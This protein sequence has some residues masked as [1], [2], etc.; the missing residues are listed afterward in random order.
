MA[1]PVH[2]SISENKTCPEPDF[3][4]DSICDDITNIFE[5]DYDGGDCCSQ[6]SLDLYCEACICYQV[7]Q[8]DAG[9]YTVHSGFSDIFCS[10]CWIN[11]NQKLKLKTKRQ[12][13]FCWCKWKFDDFFIHFE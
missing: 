9:T 4:G 7:Y 3:V 8:P 11:W 12:N 13:I 1:H 6:D 5:C 2:Y 10:I